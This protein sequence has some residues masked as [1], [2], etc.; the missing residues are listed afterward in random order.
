MGIQYN[1]QESCLTEGTFIFYDTQRPYD[2]YLNEQFDQLVLMI[3][4]EQFLQYFG[5]VERLCGHAFGEKHPLK[6]L[7]L[8][9][10]Q[11]LFKL[12][13]HAP[14]EL[15]QIVLN[16]FFD[17]LNYVTLDEMKEKIEKVSGP[18]ML[19]QIKHLIL[20]NLNNC[21]LN[22][23]DVA[24]H[25]HIS[26]RYISKL[27]QQEHTTFGRYI[28]QNRLR[29]SRNMLIKTSAQTHKINQIAYH[30]GFQDMSHF[31]REF[32]KHYGVSPGNIRK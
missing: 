24:K 31:S 15:Q 3:P 8:N 9:Y 22:I 10:A 12:P 14:V 1:G 6:F 28:L 30:C 20:E 11:D 13:E 7:L 23:H 16:K 32:K 25:F 4:R 18:I 5:R 27:F 29:L 2:L 17:L 21:E 19:L 26:S